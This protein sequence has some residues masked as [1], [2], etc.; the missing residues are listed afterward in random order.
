LIA[1]QNKHYVERISALDDTGLFVYTINVI[2]GETIHHINSGSAFYDNL[3]SAQEKAL[4]G[5]NDG[6]KKER[7][8]ISNWI[9]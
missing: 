7:F 3:H 1:S 4:I 6:S 9:A 5:E 8:S 2:T